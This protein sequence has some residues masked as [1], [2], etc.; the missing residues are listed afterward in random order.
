[1]WPDRPHPTPGIDWRDDAQTELC[2]KVFAKQE[3]LVFPPFATD[4]PTEYYGQIE[5]CPRWTAGFFKES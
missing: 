5:A 4:D 3:A 2:T 1:M